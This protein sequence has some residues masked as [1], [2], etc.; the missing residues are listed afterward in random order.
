MNEQNLVS[1]L[2]HPLAQLVVSA[3]VSS[4]TAVVTLRLMGALAPTSAPRT[5]SAAPASPGLA[6]APA[7]AD[8]TLIAAISA[9]VYATLGAHRIVYIGN[10]PPGGS[11]SWT[12]ELRSQHHTSHAVPR[13]H[14]SND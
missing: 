6:P 8:P 14:H 10:V 11:S 2:S 13:V 12:N 1:L 3:I 7:G 5:A 9:A 4:V